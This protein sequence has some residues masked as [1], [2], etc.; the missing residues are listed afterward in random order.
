MP[1]LLIE[2]RTKTIT[3]KLFDKVLGELAAEGGGIGNTFY[4]WWEEHRLEIVGLSI[5]EA[6]NIFNAAKKKKNLAAKYDEL[7]AS[8][9]W[10]EKIEFLERG[11]VELR[12]ANSKK[13]RT[14]A[15]VGALVKAS[16]KILSVILT[17]I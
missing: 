16:P 12:Y 1:S 7:V 3:K 11:V 13:L 17:V 15:L 8:M 4:E 5:A 2:A 10:K 9:S 14:M 6:I